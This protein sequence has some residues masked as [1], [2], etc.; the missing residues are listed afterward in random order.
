MLLQS[1]TLGGVAAITLG[2]VICVAIIGEYRA[3]QRAN[4]QWRERLKEHLAKSKDDWSVPPDVY[5]VPKRYTDWSKRITAA[6][7]RQLHDD[8]FDLDTLFAKLNCKTC[9]GSGMIQSDRYK[10]IGLK[11]DLCPHCYP[12]R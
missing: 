3:S 2:S 7:E 5:D 8:G 9:N 4:A 12:E 11:I 6:E 1:L 10:D